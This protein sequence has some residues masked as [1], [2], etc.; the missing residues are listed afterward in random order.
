MAGTPPR[1]CNHHAKYIPPTI[2]A[3][4]RKGKWP[5]Y[6]DYSILFPERFV[7]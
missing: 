3:L 5:T 1:Q 2:G 7:T 6:I 4:E